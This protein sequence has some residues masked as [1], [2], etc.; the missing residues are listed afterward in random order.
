MC[1]LMIVFP[2]NWIKNIYRNSKKNLNIL[3]TSMLGHLVI[4]TRGKLNRI[5]K[6]LWEDVHCHLTRYR[7]NEQRRIL[8]FFFNFSQMGFD[9]RESVIGKTK[10]KEKNRQAIHSAACKHVRQCEYICRQNMWASLKVHG[11]YWGKVK[12]NVV[13]PAQVDVRANGSVFNSRWQTN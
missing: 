10:R 2:L 13:K 11:P 4:F 9:S 3:I 12:N 7:I 6:R 5:C 8:P 1:L